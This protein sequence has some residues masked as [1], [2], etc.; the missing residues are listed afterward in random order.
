RN[1]TGVQTCALPILAPILF[2]VFGIRVVDT[3]FWTL[4]LFWLPS[5]TFLHLSMQDLSSDIRTQ[6]W[7]EV[8]ETIF[9]PYLFVP[10]LL[11]AIG[12]S[13]ERRVGNEWRLW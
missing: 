1:V 7:G 11:Q 13:E 5:Y 3:D 6:R 10:V 4:L 8:Q 12:R 9:A 2:A